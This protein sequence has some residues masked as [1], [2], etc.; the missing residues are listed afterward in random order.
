MRADAWIV[1][2][3]KSNERDI[4]LDDEEND[5]HDQV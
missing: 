1:T 2:P 3:H 5:R 4:D